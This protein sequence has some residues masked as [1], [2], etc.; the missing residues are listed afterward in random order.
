MSGERKRKKN[1]RSSSLN[2]LKNHSQ[3]AVEVIKICLTDQARVL[4]RTV[5]RERR[6]QLSGSFSALA[7]KHLLW[8]QTIRGIT[9]GKFWPPCQGPLVPQATMTVSPRY[10]PTQLLHA[11]NFT[12]FSSSFLCG[13]IQI[14]GLQNPKQLEKLLFGRCLR[15]PEIVSLKKV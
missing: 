14:H 3:K 6:K 9:R 4:Q 2:Y 15:Q 8:S 10:F 1:E 5:R 12:H 13:H 11:P 7:R